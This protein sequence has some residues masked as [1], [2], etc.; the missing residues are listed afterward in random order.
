MTVVLSSCT[1]FSKNKAT[2]SVSPL[3]DCPDYTGVFQCP[4]MPNVKHPLP[5]YTMYASTTNKGGTYTYES[6]LSISPEI[7]SKII[8]DG[9]KHTSKDHRGVTRYYR[10]TCNKGILINRY[11]VFDGTAQTEIWMDK[12]GHLKIRYD[13][14][15]GKI[16]TC[17]RVSL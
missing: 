6:H 4:E 5:A 13:F 12:D 1:V 16:L 15:E 9:K 3:A 14:A 10:A 8:A 7:K 11:S 2:P 17:K